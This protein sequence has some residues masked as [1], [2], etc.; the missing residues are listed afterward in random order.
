[1]TDFTPSDYWKGIVLYGLNNA[2]YKMALGAVLLEHAQAGNSSVSWEQLSVSFL[3]QY[4]RRLKDSP[5]PQQANP[6]RRTVMERICSDVITGRLSHEAATQKVADEAFGDVVPR[7]QTIGR[8]KGVASGRFYEA[9]FG[10]QLVLTDNLL[11]LGHEN[12]EEL[13][14]ELDARWSLLEGAFAIYQSRQQYQ[15]ANDIREIYLADGYERKSITHNVEFLQGYQGNTCF[16][17]GLP[18]RKEAH[19][20]H[21]LPRQVVHH[22][23]VWNL[24][25]SH[26]HCNLQKS[27]YLVGPHFIRKLEQR[28]ENIMGSNHPWKHKISTALGKTPKQRRENLKSH[29]E[30]VKSVLGAYHWGGSEGYNPETDVFYKR[31]ITLLNNR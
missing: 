6:A 28:N 30:N 26:D 1:M 2:T 5:M 9:D 8:D 15:L 19:V 10:K 21:V 27:D 29:Y 12:Y 16:Y 25:L 11:Q 17:C 24:V 23:S 20:D 13:G 31:L 7:F 18:I 14:S 22:D 4:L 3:N